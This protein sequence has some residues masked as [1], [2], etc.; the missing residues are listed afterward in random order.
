V[1]THSPDQSVKLRVV[2]CQKLRSLEKRYFRKFIG[3]HASWN[4]DSG[5]AEPGDVSNQSA[6]AKGEPA[7]SAL[8]S[9][10]TAKYHPECPNIL[11]YEAAEGSLG[12]LSQ[13]VDD[14]QI[15]LKVIEAAKQ[16]CRFDDP[17]Y[18]APAS[19]NDLLSYYNQRD[20][21][22]ID[23]HLIET[24][25][26]K[27]ALCVIEVHTSNKFRD[28]EEQ[29]QYM[30]RNL[31]PNSSTEKEF[32]EFLYGRGLRLPD[33]AQNR[34]DGIYCQPDFYYEPRIWV[35]CDGSPHDEPEIMRRCRTVT[36]DMRPRQEHRVASTTE[37]VRLSGLHRLR[38]S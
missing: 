19:Y 16:I 33:E 21:K 8:Q 28:Y 24:A 32:I 31:D 30:L 1:A 2:D 20:H 12:I 23:R 15:F 27:L 37:A 7:N 26:D 9:P 4:G 18:H 17:D 11:I 22:V 10:P 34:L 5:S 6:S 36:A 38:R 35:F 13:F 3:D 14:T 29:Y 25:L